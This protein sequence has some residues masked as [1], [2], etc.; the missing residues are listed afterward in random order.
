MLSILGSM[1]LRSKALYILAAMDV[2]VITRKFLANQRSPFL[3]KG[4]I[5]TFIHMSIGFWLYTAFQFRSSMSLNF[6]VFHI[7]VSISSCP[8]AFA[9]AIFLSTKSCSSWVNGPS[10]MFNYLLIILMIGSWVTS[11]G[12]PSKL[13]K[14]CFHRC[15]RFCLP[16]EVLFL[17]LSLFIVCHAILDC[18]SST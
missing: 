16:L 7:S 8:A 12:F 5:H 2:S 15:I 9:F 14:S 13:S 6:L 18:L 10:L 11:G 17:L 1:R 4:R 3:G